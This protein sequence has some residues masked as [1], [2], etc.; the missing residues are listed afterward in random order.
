MFL[1][2]YAVCIALPGDLR[3]PRGL[4]ENPPMKSINHDNW[5][6][7][8][9]NGPSPY[10]DDRSWR[11]AIFH[12]RLEGTVDR[13]VARLFE[14][15]RGGLLY[16][17]FF[18]PLLA[19]GVEQC[20]RVLESGARARCAE[21]GLAV[22]CNDNQG[23]AHPLSFGHNLRALMKE[24]LIPDAD[25]LLWQQ[26]R[27]MREWVA[28]PAHQSLLTLDHGVTALTRVAELLGRLYRGKR[29]P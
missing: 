19:M 25:L 12:V 9:A 8:D 4:R 28:T 3:L 24:G 7:A 1:V 10:G 29:S 14:A 20:Y 15:A 26:A 18:Q 27:E 13:E 21:A 22:S 23:R 6:Q 17:Y 11:E 2:L 5:L 16:G